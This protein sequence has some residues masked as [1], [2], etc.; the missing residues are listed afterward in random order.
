[1]HAFCGKAVLRG[2]Y[3]VHYR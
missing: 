3:C 2:Q 1:L